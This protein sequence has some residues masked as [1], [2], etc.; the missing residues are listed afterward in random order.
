MIELTPT[1][2]LMVYL[3]LSLIFILGVWFY[4]YYYSL[5]KPLPIMEKELHVCEFC[6]FAY[7]DTG[8][9]KITRCPRC[10]SFNSHQS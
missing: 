7:L 6:H 1:S 4:Q 5:K 3:G 8:A 2:A 9:E 10:N